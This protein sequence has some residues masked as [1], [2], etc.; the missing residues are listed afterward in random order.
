MCFLS[1]R[2][3]S[4]FGLN[5]FCVIGRLTAFPRFNNYR[6][7]S[8]WLM[9]KY[10]I[11][12]IKIFPLLSVLACFA[13]LVF[14]LPIL[15]FQFLNFTTTLFSSFVVSRFVQLTRNLRKN[16]PVPPASFQHRLNV[17]LAPHSNQFQRF[18]VRPD[19]HLRTRVK[20]HG[21]AKKG[22]CYCN[23]ACVRTVLG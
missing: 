19:S 2:H 1:L 8:S 21:I 17:L 22:A 5:I 6:W 11:D 3:V 15:V 16:I 7:T 12:S 23:C 9:S 18:F 20:A 10:T 13:M 14:Y 4:S